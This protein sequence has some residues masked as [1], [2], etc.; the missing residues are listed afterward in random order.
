[1]SIDNNNI[2][3]NNSIQFSLEYVLATGFLSKNS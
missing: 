3:N 1:M 2:D